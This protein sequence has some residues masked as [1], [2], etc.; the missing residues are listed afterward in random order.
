MRIHWRAQ[1]LIGQKQSPADKRIFMGDCIDQLTQEGEDEGDA[2]DV[3]ELLW[4][5]GSELFGE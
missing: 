2:R 3:C 5:E 1:K 4:E